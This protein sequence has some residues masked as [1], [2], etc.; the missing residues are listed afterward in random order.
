MTSLMGSG[1]FISVTFAHVSVFS[2]VQK[3]P[4]P[5]PF[6][7]Q[8]SES[9][10]ALGNLPPRFEFCIAMRQGTCGTRSTRLMRALRMAQTF[11]RVSRMPGL[12]AS[13]AM[14]KGNPPEE[15]KV[16]TYSPGSPG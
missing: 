3:T 12:G 5:W 1:A 8:R 11:A 13:F 6:V 9:T 15:G 14:K 4:R 7:A 16:L 2:F 10:R